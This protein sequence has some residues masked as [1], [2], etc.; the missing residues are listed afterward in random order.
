MSRQ[1]DS[2]WLTLCLLPGDDAIAMAQAATQ[3]RLDVGLSIGTVEIIVDARALRAA[4]AP[5]QAQECAA[6]EQGRGPGQR[7]AAVAIARGVDAAQVDK[8]AEVRGGGRQRPASQASH[9]RPLPLAVQI[10]TCGIG[11]VERVAHVARAAPT[12]LVVRCPNTRQT[13]PQR[14][15][16]VG[17]QVLR[18]LDA[19]V[20]A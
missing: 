8:R 3:D 13:L 10:V 19:L 2:Y 20:G 5:P 15:L 12:R 17:E 11:L 7:V 16:A 6:L 14:L 1:L 9:R 4:C 18:H